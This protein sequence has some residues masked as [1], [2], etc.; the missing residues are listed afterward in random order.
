VAKYFAPEVSCGAFA[1]DVPP[2][3]LAAGAAKSDAPVKMVITVASFFLTRPHL[4][5]ACWEPLLGLLRAEP[6]WL[7]GR[8]SVLGVVA[9]AAFATGMLR[10][11]SMN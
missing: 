3:A 5:D 2:A 7:R 8:A 10:E 9:I 1:I 6:V 4:I 11:Y